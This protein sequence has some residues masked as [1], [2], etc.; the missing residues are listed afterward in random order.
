LEAEGV[1]LAVDRRAGAPRDAAEKFFRI[2]LGGVE[3]A[4][5]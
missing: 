5:R 1:G 4:G 3:L 2:V